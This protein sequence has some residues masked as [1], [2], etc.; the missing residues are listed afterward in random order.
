LDYFPQIS[1]RLESRADPGDDLLSA[2]ISVTDE[3]SDSLTTA[4][5]LSMAYLLLSAGHETT[6]HLISNAVLTLVRHPDQ[7]AALLADLSLV[8]LSLVDGAVE[9]VPRFEGPM[10]SG[11]KVGH[12]S[13]S[14]N[15][16]PR[17]RR[18]TSSYSA[19]AGSGSR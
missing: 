16:S 9:E 2:Q 19:S 1:H 6:V 11:A 14:A 17:R 3:D 5:L 13:G 10:E 12:T 18:V 4:E 7:P 15:A 8:D